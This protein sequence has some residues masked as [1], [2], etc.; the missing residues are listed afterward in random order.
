MKNHFP[1]LDHFVRFRHL[2][3][4]CA[5]INLNYQ[6]ERTLQELRQR[7]RAAAALWPMYPDNCGFLVCDFIFCDPAK[8]RFNARD[9]TISD[10]NSSRAVAF[11][12]AFH[13]CLEIAQPFFTRKDVRRDGSI[14]TLP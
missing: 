9:Q 14:D 5:V 8:G 4:Y 2:D 12:A 13:R 3:C 1:R 6:P 11:L 10:G 7:L